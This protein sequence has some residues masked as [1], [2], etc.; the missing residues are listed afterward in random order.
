MNGFS[1]YFLTNMVSKGNDPTIAL[2]QVSDIY[3]YV[4]I[5][6]RGQSSINGI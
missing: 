6:N 1:G 5:I 3:I 4:Y 2:F